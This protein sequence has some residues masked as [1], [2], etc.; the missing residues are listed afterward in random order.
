MEVE[1]NYFWKL[2]QKCYFWK[3]FVGTSWSVP[4][5][6]RCWDH[7]VVVWGSLEGLLDA[8][9]LL[10]WISVLWLRMSGLAH[11]WSILILVA[12]GRRMDGKME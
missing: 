3:L 12:L 10:R 5:D 7:I 4:M 2:F 11:I 9:D 6:C 8:A 1:K